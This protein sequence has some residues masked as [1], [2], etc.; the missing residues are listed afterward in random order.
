[1]IAVTKMKNRSHLREANKCEGGWGSNYEH[2]LHSVV[3][4]MMM[5]RIVQMNQ[6]P[7]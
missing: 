4:M 3:M 2:H 1:M 5:T 7:P 6:S